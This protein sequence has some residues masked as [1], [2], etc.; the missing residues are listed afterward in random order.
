M[1]K[2]M[3]EHEQR[4]ARLPKLFT[5]SDNQEVQIS[6]KC[7]KCG[8]TLIG[9]GY[10]SRGLVTVEVDPC[11]GCNDPSWLPRLQ[12]EVRDLL[13]FE[14]EVLKRELRQKMKRRRK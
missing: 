11:P 7:R 4:A 1:R 5:W 3:K 6:M 10:V 2:R 13:R 9:Q 14:F 8:T 12:Q